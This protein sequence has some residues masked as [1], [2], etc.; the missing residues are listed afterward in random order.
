MNNSRI[1]LILYYQRS[2]KIYKAIR[3][4]KVLFNH[5]PKMKCYEWSLF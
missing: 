1:K 2:T 3:T 4:I 5:L